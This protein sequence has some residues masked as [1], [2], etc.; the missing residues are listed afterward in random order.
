MST[1]VGLVLLNWNTGE[2]TIPCLESVA[3]GS[4]R[5]ARIV[6]VD[7][8]SEDGSPDEIAARFPDVEL[9]RNPSNRGFAGGNN[10]GIQA[11]LED[12]S[13]VVWVLNNDTYVGKDCLKSLLDALETRPDA[14]GFSG[15]IFE[16]DSG[17]KIWY[18]GSVRH[19]LHGGPKH[20]LSPVLDSRVV[21]GAVEVPF[22]SGC[23]MF[24]PAPVFRRFGGFIES[25][26]AYYED[27]EW[28]WR[29][30]RRGRSMYYVPRAEMWHRVSA[31]VRKNERKAGKTN[32][33]VF[34]MNRNQLW[35]VRRHG[36]PPFEWLLC[37]AVNVAIQTRNLALMALCG[38]FGEAMSSLR[39]LRDGVLR[40]LPGDMP[41][42]GGE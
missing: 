38:R 1:R 3:A 37:V 9:I 8:G 31:S 13:D 5:P 34:L 6:V 41:V 15:K 40:R 20:L 7:N 18:A 12:R 30:S 19:P 33:R 2:F 39:A 10:L 17:G 21:N 22:I 35:T 25:Y 27:S 4:R 11:L 16:G 36:R 14:A 23:C 29:V 28:C 32:L 42:W 24:V 26:T